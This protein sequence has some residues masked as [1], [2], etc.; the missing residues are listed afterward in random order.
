MA[1]VIEKKGTC[2]IYIPTKSLSCRAEPVGCP[3]R[4]VHTGQAHGAGSPL[5]LQPRQHLFCLF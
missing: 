3:P 4:C 5:Q 2:D 1:K